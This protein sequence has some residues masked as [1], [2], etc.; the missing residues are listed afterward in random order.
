MGKADF[1]AIRRREKK[2]FKK[3]VKEHG[4]KM[5][6]LQLKKAAIAAHKAKQEAAVEKK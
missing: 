3:Y 1:A 6:D 4:K 2:D 5:I